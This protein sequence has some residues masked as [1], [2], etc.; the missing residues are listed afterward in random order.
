MP[1]VPYTQLLERKPW[2]KCLSINI[3][4]HCVR[5]VWKPMRGILRKVPYPPP[6]ETRMLR[7]YLSTN[8]P[9]YHLVSHTSPYNQRLANTRQGL[10]TKHTPH[11]YL[12]HTTNTTLQPPTVPRKHKHQT[13]H[14]QTRHMTTYRKNTHTFLYCLKLALDT[15]PIYKRHAQFTC[16]I[17]NPLHRI[18]KI[19]ITQSKHDTHITV[20]IQHTYSTHMHTHTHTKTHTLHIPCTEVHTLHIHQ[21]HTADKSHNTRCPYT[22]HLTNT[23]PQCSTY[24]LLHLCCP[25]VPMGW[26]KRHQSQGIP[27][28]FE[29]IIKTSWCQCFWCGLQRSPFTIAQG[30]F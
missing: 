26:Q 1:T 16:N 4:F 27:Y 19:S 5:S 9:N 30:C 15:H 13:Y 29:G 21:R 22:T 14:T 18:H 2:R 6:C 11:T 8:T 7:T 3:S 17:P 24:T 25:Y 20:P 10:H 28:V 12:S 23:T